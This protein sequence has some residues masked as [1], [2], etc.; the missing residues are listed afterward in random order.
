MTEL[1]SPIKSVS[2]SLRRGV[3][4][5]PNHP[6][7]SSGTRSPSHLAKRYLPQEIIL[8]QFYIASEHQNRGTG[9]QVLRDLLTEA[10]QR[11]KAISLGVMKNNPARCLYEREGF[12]HVGENDH[13]FLMKID[14][15]GDTK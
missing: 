9:T 13:K 10:R 7:W 14:A 3:P 4:S 12:K 5:Q 2:N 15:Q 1:D 8:I 6:I 11:N